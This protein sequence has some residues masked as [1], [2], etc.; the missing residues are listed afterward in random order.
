MTPLERALCQ[1][2]PWR[3]FARHVVL[4]WALGGDVPLGRVLEIGG[5]SGAMAAELLERYP[6]VTMAVSDFDDAMVTAANALRETLDA[7]GANVTQKAASRDG[8]K[9]ISSRVHL[10]LRL[11]DAA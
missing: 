4:P 2:P 1:S 3:F 10:V 5:G 9:S 6:G 7:R 11:L 8:L